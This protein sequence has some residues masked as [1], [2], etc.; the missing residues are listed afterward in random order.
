[1]ELR[2]KTPIMGWASWNAFRVDINEEK[3]KKQAD[4]LVE[5]G[6]AA[7]GYEYFNVDDGFFGGRDENGKLCYH[8]D[9]F[10]NGIRCISDYVHSLGLKAG[11]YT[12]AGDNT[13]GYYY[14]SEI[15]NGKGVGLYGYEEQDLRQFFVEENFDFLKVDWCGG[16]RLG[17]NEKEQYSKLGR[18]IEGLRQELKKPL[19][20]NV[21]RWQFPGAW[22]ADVADSWRTAADIAPNYESILHQLDNIKPLHK[23]CGPGHVNDLDMMQI[24]NGLSLEEE[25]THFAMWCMMSTPLMI[26]CDLTK[27]SQETLAILKDEELIAI[28]QDKACLQAYPVKEIRNEAGE[29]IGEVWIK[30]LGEKNSKKKAVALLNRSRESIEIAVSKKE[31]YLD[32]AIFSIR[33][34]SEHKQ[35]ELCEELIEII[36]G[37]GVKVYVIE[38]EDIILSPIYEVDSEEIPREC[39][40]IDLKE[41]LEKAENGALLVDVREKAEYENGHLNGAI[42]LPYMDIHGEV[43]FCLKDKEQELIV[44]CATGKRSSQAEE[45]LWY[46]GYK[47]VYYLGGIENN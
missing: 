4:C 14:D 31:L 5:S 16:V 19:V 10:P 1:M 33:D 41:A 12:E 37:C 39:K 22:V 42:N 38:A 36:T 8:K 47:N 11:I 18:I 27:L 35:V 29:L 26:G 32:G 40:R 44:Y 15:E 30:D 20:Y 6:L 2:R 28:H 21:C 45:S 7:C 9:R 43:G 23:Y 3:L 34:V 13:C 46:L 25:K 24:G 17:L